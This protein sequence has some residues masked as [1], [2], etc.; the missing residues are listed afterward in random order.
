MIIKMYNHVFYPQIEKKIVEQKLA[1][2]NEQNEN[3][4]LLLCDMINEKWTA[5]DFKD[6]YLAIDDIADE[7]KMK[8]PDLPSD[9]TVISVDE[10][11]KRCI[12]YFRKNRVIFE[13]FLVECI[14][15]GSL[16]NIFE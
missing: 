13:E 15:D 9:I 11:K 7:F 6:S 1:L 5:N 8:R 10:V 4:Q 16:P 2:F 14:A 3:S 12:E